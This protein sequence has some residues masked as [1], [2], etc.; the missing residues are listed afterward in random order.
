MG[1][2]LAALFL[3][4]APADAARRPITG[5]L[6]QPGLTVIAVADNG[7]ARSVRAGRGTFGWWPRPSA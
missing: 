7:Q 2:L 4:A 1:V 5:T 3:A 6:S